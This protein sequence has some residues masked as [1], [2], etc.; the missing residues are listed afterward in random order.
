MTKGFESLSTSFTPERKAN[1]NVDHETPP[2]N[3]DPSSFSTGIEASSSRFASVYANTSEQT[4]VNLEASISFV[5]TSDRMGSRSGEQ[6]PY[7]QIDQEYDPQG[8]IVQE[9]LAIQFDTYK[10][11]PSL[12][13]ERSLDS[14]KRVCHI[15]E[16]L[17]FLAPM[18]HERPWDCP[19][20]Y[21]ALTF[22]SKIPHPPTSPLA[23]LPFG[24][25][26][27][28]IRAVNHHWD[29]LSYTLPHPP[30]S[31]L[32]NLPFGE[33]LNRI[34]AVNH[35]WDDLSYTRIRRARDR[36]DI[37]NSEYWV[38]DMRGATPG[39]D[40]FNTPSIPIRPRKSRRLSELSN[41]S[42]AEV[43]VDPSAVIPSVTDAADMQ[44]TD[45]ASARGS[46]HGESNE[47]KG[48]DYVFRSN[49]K[50]KVDPVDKKA[51]KK[52]ITAKLKPTSKGERFPPSGSVELV[53]SFRLKHP[54]LKVWVSH[55]LL[56]FLLSTPATTSL[57]RMK[58]KCNDEKTGS[59]LLRPA[60]M[61]MRHEEK[62]R[63]EDEVKKRDVHLEAASAAI[64]ELRA[65]PEKSR[66]T[67][68]CLRKER[69]GARRRADE[70]ASAHHAQEEVKAQLYYRRGAQI[71]L[72]KM[73]KAEYKLPP[74]LL[75][76]YAKE[77][78]EYL[79][80]VESLAADS[81]G[82]DI[83]FPTPPPPPAGPPRDSLSQVPE[84]ISEHGSF[85]S[86]QD[87][88]DGDLV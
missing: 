25:D 16:E 40:A 43:T 26:L 64:V 54:L 29:D 3:F 88:Q 35:H 21:S 67:E 15:S 4:S 8:Q 13:D 68:D 86:P 57:V 53:K 84:G 66:F 78:K 28:R 45:D 85:L 69:D 38:A 27:N 79:A 18:S 50:G 52:R 2:V 83:L 61:W 6:D 30:T 63:L 49:G 87:N 42:E 73:V 60:P 77:E 72:E 7:E 33:D 31:P 71:S 34:R 11:S 59:R 20:S 39:I 1:L 80:K 10:I 51:E 41:R 19:T 65:N 74:G 32:A 76:N 81:L 47:P 56:L 75:E 37:R 24:E 82:D 62:Q 48:R 5:D 70:I 14:M 17:E 58:W 36:L 9:I 55:L 22:Q 12:S 46:V 44:R 23:N